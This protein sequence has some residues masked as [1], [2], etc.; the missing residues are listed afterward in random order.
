VSWRGARHHVASRPAWRSGS[1]G[2][3][4]S[5]FQGITIRHEQVSS[6]AIVGAGICLT[7]AWVIKP[8]TTE[9][10]QSRN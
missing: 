3:R 9:T 1:Q 6:V 4:S 2:L 8:A 7:G 5:H 10:A